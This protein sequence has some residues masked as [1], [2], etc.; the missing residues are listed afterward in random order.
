MSGH[1]RIHNN[2]STK[3]V[4][5]P[6]GVG[7]RSPTV[8]EPANALP[9]LFPARSGF[10]LGGDSKRHSEVVQ[11]DQGLRLHPTH[12]RRQRRIRAYLSRRARLSVDAQRWPSRRIRGC[13]KSRQ[14]FRAVQ[15]LDRCDA[16]AEAAS[17]NEHVKGLIESAVG[18]LR[19]L[20][21]S[22][23]V[24]SAGDNAGFITK[25]FIGS[26]ADTLGEG[27][28]SEVPERLLLGPRSALLTKM[29]PSRNILLMTLA[30]Q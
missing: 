23:L 24:R 8:V 10:L 7:T 25:T 18:Q 11:L 27:R 16:A 4:A 21:N 13:R 26:V 1:R 28:Q 12:R 22:F 15:H 3:S 17:G 2:A 9:A 14:N 29:F 19:R 20:L 6:A 5:Y 30:L